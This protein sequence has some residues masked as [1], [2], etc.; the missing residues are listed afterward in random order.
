MGLKIQLLDI[1]SRLSN[2]D[3]KIGVIKNGDNNE[4]PEMMERFINNSVTAKSA[5]NIMSIYI[6][7]QGFAEKNTEKVSKGVDLKLFTNKVSKSIAKHH[8]VFIHVKYDGNGDRKTFDTL[9]YS[10]CRLGKKDDKDYN[11]KIAV[12]NDWSANKIDKNKI[13]WFD[14]YN[15]NKTVVNSQIQNQAGDDLIEKVNNYKG[16]ILYINLDEEY[17]YALSTIDAVK[18]DCDSEAQSSVFKNQSLRKGFTGKTVVVTRPLVGAQNDYET[19]EL[20][21]QAQSERKSFKTTIE[22][23]IGAENAGGVLHVEL[24]QEQDK[25]DDAIKFENIA[26]DVDDKIF[27]YTEKSVFLNILMAFNNLPSG[28]VRSDGALFSAGGEAIMQMKLDYQDNTKIERNVVEDIVNE[29]LGSSDGS[30]KL[31]PLIVETE[32]P[33][34]ID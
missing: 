5:A 16:Q 30:Y 26:S 11:G 14:V 1:L 15:P 31:I 9:P 21:A 12:Y 32:K 22:S 23:F 27:E 2:F 4:Y 13:L 3:K 18:Y 8:G 34:E 10:H 25:L 6:A 28:L 24:E 33:K 19:P 29:L 17:D 20:Y 7:G